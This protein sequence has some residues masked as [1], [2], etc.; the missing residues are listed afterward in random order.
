MNRLVEVALIVGLSS[1]G[2]AA[3]AQEPTA[4]AAMERYR[5]LF[6][7]PAAECERGSVPDEVTVC[8]RRT[9]DPYRLPL[10]V[11]PTP[12][13]RVAGEAPDQVAASEVG[14]EPCSTIGPMGGCGSYVPIIP[15]VMWVAKTAV[16]AVK[17]AEEDE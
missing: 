3:A 6:K 1:T 16:K 7:G 2:P 12:G 15:F 10:P 13:T 9:R 17:A 14:S 8:G 4:E 5:K 11:E